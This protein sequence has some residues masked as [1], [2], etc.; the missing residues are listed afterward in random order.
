MDNRLGDWIYQH[1]WKLQYS[2]SYAIWTAQKFEIKQIILL[3]RAITKRT[4]FI[5]IDF[6]AEIF[7]SILV[8][9]KRRELKKS[10]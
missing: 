5:T 2:R 8:S 9:G 7:F 10:I 3:H 4:I 6:I 1:V